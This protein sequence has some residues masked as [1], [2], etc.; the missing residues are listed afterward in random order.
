M[1][2]R[3]LLE[4]AVN[5]PV[6]M[7]DRSL[8]RGVVV[9]E[10][11]MGGRRCEYV[12]GLASGKASELWNV[13]LNNEA[14]ARLQVCCGI[15]KRLNLLIL[16]DQIGDGVAKKVD[17]A[18]GSVDLRCREVADRYIDVRRVVLCTQLRNHRCGELD[19]LHP[20]APV[21]K[22]DGDAA[23]ANAEFKS[24]PCPSQIGKELDGW[25]NY[26]RLEEL[27]PQKVK[28]LSNPLVEV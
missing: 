3:E 13:V 23:G 15:A 25:L 10:A 5:H 22:G 7:R 4:L 12:N 24:G 27:W 28:P 21:A 11:K 26:P 6:V 19:S 17:E 18:Q 9:L 2:R 1:C 16:C 20:N 8:V 14:A